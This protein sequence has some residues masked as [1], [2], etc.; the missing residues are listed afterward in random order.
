MK[1]LIFSDYE[2]QELKNFYEHQMQKM[3]ERMELIQNILDKVAGEAFAV[4]E[5]VLA[6][7]SRQEKP[8][9][10]GKSL[11]AE[12][13]LEKSGLRATKWNKFIINTLLRLRR[14]LTIQ[15]LS[16]LAAKEFKI[17][18]EE[19]DKM[20]LTINQALIRIRK[21]NAVKEYKIKGLKNKYFGL[22]AW[23]DGNRLL[24]DFQKLLGLPAAKEAP[25][26]RGRKPK[27]DDSKEA[28]AKRGRKKKDSKTPVAKTKVRKSKGRKAGRKKS[29]ALA[30][31]SAAE[32]MPSANTPAGTTES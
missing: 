9:A 21:S 25:A 31:P 20:R 27:V 5:A 6:A 32:E 2:L 22:E 29:Q 12:E 18:P 28:P 15:E 11:S 30:T 26:K 13:I 1:S 14:P 17:A 16:E 8:G 7:E 10:S 19:L 24:D 23:F 4:A 3:R